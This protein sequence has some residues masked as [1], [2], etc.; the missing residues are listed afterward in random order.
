VLRVLER[1]PRHLVVELSTGGFFAIPNPDGTVRLEAPGFE[2]PVGQGAAIPVKRA[3]VE[4]V[5]GREV[6]LSARALEL[7]R[8]GGLAPAAAGTPGVVATRRGTVHAMR[9]SEAG[10]FRAEGLYPADS[11]R[12]LS[13]GFQ[14]ETKKA[15][16]EL[17]PLRWDGRSGELLLARRLLVRLTF[18]GR[19]RGEISRGGSRGRQH[20]ASRSHLERSVLARFKAKDRGLYRV[21]F[22]SLGVRRGIP[23]SE[24]RLSRLGEPV[25]FHLEPDRE[26]FGP[27]SVLYFFSQGVD[28]NPYGPAAVYELEQGEGAS[29]MPQVK[30]PPGGSSLAYF[31]QR[32]SRE[33]NRYYQAGLLEASDPWLWDVLLAP[34]EKTYFFTV[35]DQE[36]AAPSSKLAVWLQGASE[37]LG[38]PDH[39]VRVRVNGVV[40]AETTWDGKTPREIAVE[41]DTGLLLEG[42]NELAVENV[43]DTSAPYSMVMLDR[44]ELVYP[45]RQQAEGGV[46]E[47]TWSESGAAEIAGLPVDVRIVDVTENPPRW[48]GGIEAW[49][50]GTRFQ[51][52]ANRTYF[53][54]AP[55]ALLA[56]EV[57]R[58][59]SGG[60]RSSRNR[61]DYLLLAPRAFLAAA[62][63]LV[64]L[65]RSQALVSRAVA[66]EEI[67][68]EFGFGEERPEALREFLAHAF[69]HWRRPSPRYVLLLGDATYDFKDFLQTGVR[70]Q[71]PPFMTKTAYLW[72]ASDPA[73]ASINGDDELPDLALGRLPAASTEE[74]RILVEKILA[75]ERLAQGLSRAAALVADNSDAAG[76]FEADAEDIAAGPLAGRGVRKI[77]LGALGAPAAS[78]AILETF[79]EGAGLL[80]YIGHGGIHLWA[81]ENIFDAARVKELSPQADQPL[82]LTLNCLNGYFHFPYFNALSEELVKAEG[83]GAI[84]AFSPSGLS[85]NEP[86][87][88]LH[89]ALAAEIVSGRHS[90]LGDALMAAQAA[91]AETGAFPELLRIYHL[92]GDPAL[93]LR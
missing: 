61:A 53:A 55:D 15:L 30:I 84:A 59:V 19:A 31:W 23:A 66:I 74:V 3:W 58:P 85:L 7:E 13:V 45:R 65:R 29:R 50:G 2:Q 8:I 86:A 39:H 92:F 68:S 33:E 4:A 28:L 34:A 60:L 38:S 14:G 22:E 73:Y 75:F 25:A 62:E 37:F 72:T 24:L 43:N 44:F 17:A 69:H 88:L 70:N 87:H 64:E 48:L 80:S 26:L 93:A 79:D 91:Y 78:R 90:R 89:R 41:I 47:G 10:A 67:Y 11:A 54:A 21:G 12:V 32:L 63:P 81:A 46:L 5:A 6:A 42:E 1:G 36:R 71:V 18:E 83:R 82:V 9:P 52:E 20:R 76:N 40:V 16:L 49:R 51:V 56:P 57:E 77:Y 27:G 35:R